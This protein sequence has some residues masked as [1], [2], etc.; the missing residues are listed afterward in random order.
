VLLFAVLE[1][2]FHGLVAAAYVL[3]Y[4]VFGLFAMWHFIFFICGA[5][6]LG[7]SHELRRADGSEI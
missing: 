6:A 1:F 2:L 5:A 3:A 7:T 4:S